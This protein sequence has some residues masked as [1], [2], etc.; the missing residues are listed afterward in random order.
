MRFY[1]PYFK[2]PYESLPDLSSEIQKYVEIKET[3]VIT[4]L[5][6]ISQDSYEERLNKLQTLKAALEDLELVD[7]DVNLQLGRVFSHFGRWKEA[8]TVLQDGIRLT[9][10]ASKQVWNCTLPSQRHTCK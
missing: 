2:Y 6:W 10:P 5:K 1:K 7:I 9:H 8:L 3:M 4:D